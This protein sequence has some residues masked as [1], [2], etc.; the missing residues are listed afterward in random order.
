MHNFYGYLSSVTMQGLAPS[1]FQM[2]AFLDAADVVLVDF[3]LG[4]GRLAN[5]V[6]GRWIGRWLGGYEVEYKVFEGQ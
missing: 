4:T 2:L 1:P 5:V 6:I 3:P